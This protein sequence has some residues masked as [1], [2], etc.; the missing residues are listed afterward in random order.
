MQGF[1]RQLEIVTATNR[2]RE[3]LSLVMLLFAKLTWLCQR[4]SYANFYSRAERTLYSYSSFK[5]RTMK[6]VLYRL[7]FLCKATNIW[8][9]CLQPF[10]VISSQ[11]LIYSSAI[12]VKPWWMEMCRLSPDRSIRTSCD[13]LEKI[14]QIISILLE[15]TNASGTS[16]N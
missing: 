10:I 12:N 9:C 16:Y 3:L 7:N 1:L 15:I 8:F 11:R 14:Y 5:K 6:Q 4:K 2:A 13:S